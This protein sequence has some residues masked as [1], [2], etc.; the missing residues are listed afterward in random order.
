MSAQV[1]RDQAK[2]LNYGRIYGAGEPFAKLLLMQFNPSLSEVE[3]AGRAKHMY[4]QTK[5]SR[6]HTLNTRGRWVYEK[7]SGRGKYSGEHLNSGEV[8]QLAS[9]MAQVLH[10]VKIPSNCPDILYSGQH[11]LTEQGQELLL[12]LGLSPADKVDTELLNKLVKV[13]REGKH[14]I[15]SDFETK[16]S[17]VERVIWS[18]GSESATFNRLEVEMFFFIIFVFYNYEL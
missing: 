3:A 12:G 17:L 15:R 18:G 14:R 16:E 10:L 11:D 6:A 4:G 9:I 8:G 5:G 2:I 1:T 13:S 7:L